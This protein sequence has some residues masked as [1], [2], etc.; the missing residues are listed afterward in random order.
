VS[1]PSSDRL[2]ID[3]VAADLRCSRSTVFRLLRERAFPS[4]KIGR[5]RL[6]ERPDVDAYVARIK[7]GT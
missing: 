2:T 3:D 4:V 7:G 6:I 1:A 5:Q